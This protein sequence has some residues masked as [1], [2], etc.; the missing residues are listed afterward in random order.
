MA[1]K[2]RAETLFIASMPANRLSDRCG[3]DNKVK[4]IPY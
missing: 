3:P 4:Y 2:K 1:L